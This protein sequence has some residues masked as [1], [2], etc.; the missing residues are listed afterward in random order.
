MKTRADTI[1]IF[2]AFRLQI[3]NLFDRKIKALQS[4]EAKEYLSS[5]FQHELQNHGI[6][7]HISCPHTPQQNGT[8]EWKHRHIVDM[9]LTV[10]AH[11]NLP[12]KFWDFAFETAVY[13]IN[14]LPTRSLRFLSPYQVLHGSPPNYSLLHVFGCHC[15]PYLRP[16]NTHK[17]Q[18]RSRPCLFLGYTPNFLGYCCLDLVSGRLFIARTIIFD[19]QHF[20]FTSPIVDSPTHSNRPEMFLMPSPAGSSPSHSLSSLPLPLPVLSPS[21]IG[22]SPTNTAVDVSDQVTPDTTVSDHIVDLIRWLPSL[23]M[24]LYHHVNSLLVSTLLPSLLPLTP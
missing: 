13:L 15:F 7:H 9:G 24:V 18:F 19:E 21:S 4:D 16:Y 6:V 8:A 20:P 11:A 2:H 10:L 3:E 14:Q 1:K 22:P 5:D 17:L 12:H 23:R